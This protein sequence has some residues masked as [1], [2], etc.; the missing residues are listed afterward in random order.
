MLNITDIVKKNEKDLLST[1]K[2]ELRRNVRSLTVEQKQKF[3]G[4]LSQ[5]D[6]NI[7]EDTLEANPDV[8][9]AD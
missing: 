2:T 4:I 6:P 8:K 3:V 7:G 1:E 5:S 9:E